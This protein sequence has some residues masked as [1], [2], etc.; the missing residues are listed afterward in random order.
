VELSDA[1][2]STLAPV[3]LPEPQKLQAKRAGKPEPKF[4]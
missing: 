4:M 2:I 1:F 3:A